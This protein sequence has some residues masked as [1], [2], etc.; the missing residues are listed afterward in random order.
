MGDYR[1]LCLAPVV[2]VV[3]PAGQH[4]PA[5]GGQLQRRLYRSS[6]LLGIVEIVLAVR[7]NTWTGPDAI[8]AGSFV[9]RHGSPPGR[10]GSAT[11]RSIRGDPADQIEVVLWRSPADN[12]AASLPFESEHDLQSNGFQVRFGSSRGPGGRS[13]Q[14]SGEPSL[15]VALAVADCL[16]T[17]LDVGGTGPLVTHLSEVADADG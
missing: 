3:R 1:R 11:I 9:N 12:L 15:D 7:L 10:A 2:E 17:H 8:G 5:G 13:P 4:R 16:A 6:G 14:V